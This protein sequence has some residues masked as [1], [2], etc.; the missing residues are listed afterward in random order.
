[1]DASGKFGICRGFNPGH[2]TEVA[3]G[4]CGPNSCK[5]QGKFIHACNLCGE[6]GHTHKECTSS[7]AKRQRNRKGGK[8]MGKGG[9]VAPWKGWGKT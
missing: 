6:V 7:S 2:C 8:G 5:K 3:D 9:F 4:K 1:M